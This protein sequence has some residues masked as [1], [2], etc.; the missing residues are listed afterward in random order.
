MYA[1]AYADQVI[2]FK[3]Q[4][5]EQRWKIA[6]SQFTGQVISSRMFYRVE[7]PTYCSLLLLFFLSKNS[8][9]MTELFHVTAGS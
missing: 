3:L 1:S 5:P 6:Q 9:P 7:K 8:F 2:M 4:F